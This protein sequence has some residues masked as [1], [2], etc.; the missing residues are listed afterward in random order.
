MKIESFI[1]EKVPLRG[2]KQRAF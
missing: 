1:G 2:I